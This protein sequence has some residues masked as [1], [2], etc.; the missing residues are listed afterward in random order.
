MHRI[1]PAA[2]FAIAI[3]AMP[4]HA[5][6]EGQ[7]NMGQG[8]RYQGYLTPRPATV[9]VYDQDPAQRRSIYLGLN[10]AGHHLTVARTPDDLARALQGKRNDLVI[11]HHG[12]ADANDAAPARLLPV[13]Q[14]QQRNETS[15]RS[16]FRVFLLD[17]ASLGQYLKGIDQLVRG[18]L[19]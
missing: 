1:I 14:R 8:M 15:V 13:V 2:A 11:T 3:I 9:L 6:G 19:K 10:R 4:A 16:R 17:G 12:N 5:C 18:T 7:F